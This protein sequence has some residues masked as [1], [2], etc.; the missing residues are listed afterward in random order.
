MA[1]K[2]DRPFP[3]YEFELLCVRQPKKE[4][5]HQRGQEDTKFTLGETK[6]VSAYYVAING[7]GLP[8]ISL[9]NE[10]EKLANFASLA[11]RKVG[12]TRSISLFCLT[13]LLDL[14]QQFLLVF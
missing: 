5:S 7:P 11:P 12:K 6:K 9:K 4:K 1:P 2:I 14:S 13:A 10:L 8:S 3:G